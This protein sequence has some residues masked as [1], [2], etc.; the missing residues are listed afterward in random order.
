MVI[1]SSNDLSSSNQNSF[2]TKNSDQFPEMPIPTMAQG[3]PLTVIEE[4]ENDDKIA[5]RR[6]V[7]LA[8]TREILPK[9]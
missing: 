3:E 1:E 4:E 6:T 9:F 8:D 7:S 5:P 2:L